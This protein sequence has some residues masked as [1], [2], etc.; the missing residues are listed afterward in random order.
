MLSGEVESHVQLLTR[1]VGRGEV[2]S[3]L[4]LLGAAVHTVLRDQVPAC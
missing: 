3:G 1:H 4:V 2:N